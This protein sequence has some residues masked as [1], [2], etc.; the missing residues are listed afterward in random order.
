MRI[1]TLILL[2]LAAATPASAQSVD[3]KSIAALQEAETGWNRAYL[4]AP[5][6]Q[7]KDVLTWLRLREGAARFSEYQAFIA[8]HG[9]WPGVGRLRA[10]AEQV[11]E[12]GHDR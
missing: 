6:Q 3:P 1:V 4:L 7:T 5:D 8:S 12:E 11:I 10:E 2:E 9:D